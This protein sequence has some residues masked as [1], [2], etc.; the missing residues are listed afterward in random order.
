MR[1][2]SYLLKGGKSG[3]LYSEKVKRAD[4]E[5]GKKKKPRN[6]EKTFLGEKGKGKGPL[7]KGFPEYEEET[8]FLQRDNDSGRG[9]GSTRK[10]QGAQAEELRAEGQ[11]TE[12]E[13]H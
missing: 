1:S 11:G 9:E 13:Y 10:F 12:V 2:Q 6:E 8:S 7:V 5:K 3:I 4:K